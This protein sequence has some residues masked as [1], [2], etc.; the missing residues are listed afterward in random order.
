MSKR[1]KTLLSILLTAFVVM[2]VLFGYKWL[3]TKKA[4]IKT[5]I[6]TLEAT[7]D[8]ATA[9]EDARSRV[10]AE[11][12]W[13]AKHTPEPKEAELAPSRL[14][15]F[16]TAEAKR[17]GLTVKVPRILENDT[18]GVHYE[19]ARFQITVTGR[20]NLLWTWLVKLHSPTEF[21]AVTQLQLSPNREDDTLIDAQV[22]VE[23]WFVPKSAENPPAPNPEAEKSES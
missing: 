17:A 7:L 19:R 1:E 8:V 9:A 12:T 16:T 4:A 3:S 2:L 15:S 18:S 22:Q 23:E 10:A 13:L 14:E 21:R 11:E 5:E 6:E 20:E